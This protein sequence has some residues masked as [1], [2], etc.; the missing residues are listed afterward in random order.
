MS[1][2]AKLMVTLTPEDIVQGVVNVLELQAAPAEP[3]VVVDGSGRV[4][5]GTTVPGAGLEVGCAAQF[6]VDVAML[7]NLDVTGDIR[8]RGN[9]VTS[10]DRRLKYNLERITDAVEKIKALTGYTYDRADRSGRQ[11]GLVAQDVAA[12]LPEATGF[13]GD[14]YMHVAY[15]NIM[16]LVV[17]A[18][19]D[20]AAEV[21]KLKTR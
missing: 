1:G 19:K 7:G 3:C 9:V 6:D 2:H 10:S 11:T 12:V 15:G 8:N 20:L 14:G 16:G 5:V 13:D 18:I 21:E 17:E 4:G